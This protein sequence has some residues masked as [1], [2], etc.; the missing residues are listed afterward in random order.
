M[1]C[2]VCLCVV[3]VGGVGGGRWWVFVNV[4]QACMIVH[5]SACIS[6]CIW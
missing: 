3:V 4:M 1:I 5:T 2:Y 6:M